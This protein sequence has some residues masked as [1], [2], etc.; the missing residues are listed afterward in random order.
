[1]Q[2]QQSKGADGSER[3]G[4]GLAAIISAIAFTVEG[5]L[6]R[7]FGV[8]FIGMKGPL[9]FGFIALFAAFCPRNEVLPLLVYLGVYT[10]LWIVAQLW[11]WYRRLRRKIEGHTRYS[12]IPHLMRLFP[13]CRETTIKR[14]EPFLVI[15]IGY[16]IHHVN[17]PLGD[18]LMTAGGAFVLT[19]TLQIAAERE[20]VLDMNDAVASQRVTANSFRGLQN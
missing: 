3:A 8:R 7:N 12:G 13:W 4:K 15:L 10:L 18:F 5:V 20:R 11:A 2:Q 19:A 1:M 17:G 9:G 16:S 14:L 6:H